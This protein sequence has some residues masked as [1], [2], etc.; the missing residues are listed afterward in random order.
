MFCFCRLL[1]S[2]LRDVDSS[3]SAGR[4]C[5]AS[6]VNCIAEKTVTGHSLSDHARHYF[7]AMNSD[8]DLLSIQRYRNFKENFQPYNCIM[9]WVLKRRKK[10]KVEKQEPLLQE[11]T[12]AAA[13]EFESKAATSLWGAGEFPTQSLVDTRGGGDVYMH[14]DA[15]PTRIPRLSVWCCCLVGQQEQQLSPV[16]WWAISIL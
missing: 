3:R 7:P 15:I 12:A 13:L 6:Q 14:K 16:C 9:T 1:V 2:I 10:E 11:G 4:F 8:R 5:P